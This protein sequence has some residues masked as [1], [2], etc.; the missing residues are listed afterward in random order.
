MLQTQVFDTFFESSTDKLPDD[1][2]G[3]VA[4]NIFV[5]VRF[6]FLGNPLLSFEALLGFFAVILH[7]ADILNFED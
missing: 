5:V 1:L 7:I 2:F 6:A 4:T 3:D